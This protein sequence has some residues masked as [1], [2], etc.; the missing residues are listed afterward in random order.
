MRYLTKPFSALLALAIVIGLSPRPARAGCSTDTTAGD[1]AN[2][3][4]GSCYIAQT[5]DGEVVLPPTEGSEFS[6]VALPAGWGSFQWDPSGTVTVGGGALA[7]D[8]AL[9]RTD[10]WWS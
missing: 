2:G 3:T 10:A 6:G 5:A 1:F 4:S 9:A 8:A 7:V